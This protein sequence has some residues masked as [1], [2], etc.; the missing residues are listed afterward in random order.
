MAYL[1]LYRD[2]AY[3]QTFFAFPT[4]HMTYSSHTGGN[5]RT[6]SH[7]GKTY[8]YFDGS[9][10]RF[11]D[12]QVQNAAATFDNRRNRVSHPTTMY[13][14]NGLSVEVKESTDTN[15]AGGA[16]RY[17]TIGGQRIADGDAQ[18]TNA[19]SYTCSYCVEF[20]YAN[21][22]YIGF[23]AWTYNEPW[24]SSMRPVFCV[25]KSFWEDAIRPPYNYGEKPD[26]AGGQGS[27]TIPD[28]GVHRSANPQ[29]GIPL[30]GRGLHAYVA[31]PAGY[32][33]L[34][35]YLWGEGNTLAKSLWQKFL[36]KTHNPSSC[37]VACFRLPTIFMPTVGT[38]S[39]VQI[40]GINLPT[41]G[42]LAVDLGYK[43]A[44]ISLGTLEPP[45]GSWL[46]YCGVT[47]K[48]YI[49]F[50]GEI[51]VD[52]AQIFN[53]EIKIEYRCDTFNGNLGATV[54]AGNHQIADLTTNVAY[55]IPVSGGDT[56]TLDRIGALATGALAIAAAES[57]GAAMAAVSGLAAGFAGSQYKTYLNNSN[58][59]GSVNSCIN[60][61]AYVE[62][63]APTT[64]YP[65][66]DSPAYLRAYGL[67][68]PAFSGQLSAFAGGYG[69]F[70]VQK[71]AGDT[72][73]ILGA[74]DEEKTEIIRLLGEGVIV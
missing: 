47:C 64:A 14:K 23:S 19:E 54:F 55:P 8:R 4:L 33:S 29:A 15:D 68:A 1:V 65:Y 69:E 21:V 40:A 66:Q 17:W 59:S 2:A 3:T 38:A 73:S 30:G 57:G 31:T 37:V 46:D 35:E 32:R 50:C 34:Q 20:E 36:N 52:A 16:L 18:A 11:Y 10:Y 51:A 58:T 43:H 74:S 26:D 5:P 49:P 70:D 13:L 6:F 9:N 44:T 45:F 41:T 63:I 71:N 25:E 61:V 12:A 56:G 27:G 72:I 60:G 53:R 22:T 7:G 39:G 24:S 42:T 48:I 62:Y 28:T 67:P